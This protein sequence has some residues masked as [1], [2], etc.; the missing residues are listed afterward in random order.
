MDGNDCTQNP[1]IA[2]KLGIDI[3]KAYKV[4]RFKRKEDIFIL[5][6][7]SISTLLRIS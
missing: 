7:E 3:A 1:A 4:I 2:V 5:T 6:V